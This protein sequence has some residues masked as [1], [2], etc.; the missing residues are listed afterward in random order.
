MIGARARCSISLRRK[1]GRVLV[2]DGKGQLVLWGDSNGQV[3]TLICKL[4]EGVDTRPPTWWRLNATSPSDVLALL[5]DACKEQVNDALYT[6]R[7]R[8][9]LTQSR[10][11]RTVL[12]PLVVLLENASKS[13]V[14]SLTR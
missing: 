12:Q 9:S 1:H 6:L 4:L 8:L 11:Q 13:Y 5:D 7:K 14:N 10:K 2:F 3:V